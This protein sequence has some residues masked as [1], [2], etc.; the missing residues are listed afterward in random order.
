[1]MDFIKEN[2]RYPT[3]SRTMGV[4]GTV[5]VSFI[6]WADGKVS[7]ATVIRGIN[8]S[9]DREAKRVVEMSPDWKPGKQSGRPVSVRFVLPIKFKLG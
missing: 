7:D 1:M 4:E 5:Y 3:E 8:E 6:V 9:C 2:L